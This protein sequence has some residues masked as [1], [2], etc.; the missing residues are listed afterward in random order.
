MSLLQILANNSVL[1]AFFISLACLRKKSV[2]R[3]ENTEFKVLNHKLNRKRPFF[4]SCFQYFACNLLYSL[5]KRSFCIFSCLN[6]RSFSNKR[7]LRD[8]GSCVARRSSLCLTCPH[9]VFIFKL[10]IFLILY[11]IHAFYLICILYI[12]IR[13]IFL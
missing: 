9:G 3:P 11:D 7:I 1:K 10:F 2:Y 8:K 13:Q 5:A 6:R 4:S 12:F